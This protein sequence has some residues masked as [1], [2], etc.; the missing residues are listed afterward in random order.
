MGPL[1]PDII[2]NNLNLI[3]ALIIGIAFGAILEQAGFSSSKKLV[4][5]FYG[6]DF[7]VLRVFFTAG[8]TAMVGI[9]GLNY[10]GLID[11]NFVYI[12]PLFVYSAI[13]G[14][15]I[16]GLGFILG[17]YCPGTS[18]CGAAIGKTDAMIFIG[19]LFLGVFAFAE[20]YPLFE[21]LYKSAYLGSPTAYEMLGISQ[22]LFALIMVAM[23]FMAFYMVTI[24]ENKV[25]GLQPS[26]VKI[27]PGV[28]SI[29]ILALIL[30][31]GSL[32]FS[33]RKSYLIEKYSSDDILS[34]STFNV[35]SVDEFA[36]RLLDPYEER[37][38]I[39]DFRHK[40][41]NSA[42][43]PRSLDISIDELF[44]KEANKLLLK[45][46]TINL[47]VADTEKEE[48][49]YAAIAKELGYKNIWILEGGFEY[50]KKSILEYEPEDINRAIAEGNFILRDKIKFRT[51]AKKEINEAIK[52]SKMP[53]DTKKEKPKRV[54]G[55]C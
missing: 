34:K 15:I 1:A 16:M 31:L 6:Y 41:S 33:D 49:K 8:V 51:K 29:I 9:M 13:V 20:G 14:G 30:F 22:N 37:L 19:G 21:D 43:L 10:F 25:N 7:T 11:L 55:G 27:T 52:L 28:V 2:G 18:F 5:L 54:L 46:R 44:G 50:F 53:K 12:N 23:A 42:I 3:I 26:F 4:G 38:Q 24:I 45:N 40:D 47:F 17:G 48:K 32:F 35:M 39:F 36:F